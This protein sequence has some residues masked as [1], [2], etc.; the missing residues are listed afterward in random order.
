MK[1]HSPA[2]IF[3][4]IGCFLGSIQRVHGSLYYTSLVSPYFSLRLWFASQAN[5]NFKIS[6]GSVVASIR[7]LNGLLHSFNLSPKTHRR[8]LR[9]VRNLIVLVRSTHVQDTTLQIALPLMMFDPNIFVMIASYVFDIG[10][11][12]GSGFLPDIQFRGAEYLHHFYVSAYA[13]D[14]PPNDSSE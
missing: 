14:M 12:Q 8:H 13:F 2:R 7:C 1:R 4:P 11:I 10:N 9:V 6:V 3:L 5:F